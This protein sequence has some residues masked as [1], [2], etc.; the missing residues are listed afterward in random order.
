MRGSRLGLV[1]VRSA[2]AL[3][4]LAA[5]VVA[6]TD[7]SGWWWTAWSA[8]LAV[9]IARPVGIVNLGRPVRVVLDTPVVASAIVLLS[10]A[11]A[12]AA[13][14]V[15]MAIGLAAHTAAGA[16]PH[17]ALGAV[18]GFGRHAI[19]ATAAA[20]LV[21]GWART[22][23]ASMLVAT[24]AA[25][26]C[27]LAVAYVSVLAEMALVGGRLDVLVLRQLAAP[28]L[29][30]PPAV[31]LA[32]AAVRLE[33]AGPG[34]SLLLALPVAAVA[35]ATSVAS[36]SRVE[37]AHAGALFLVAEAGAVVDDESVVAD[38]LRYAI[39]DVLAHA[40]PSGVARGVDGSLTVTL[41][42]PDALDDA[43]RV[44]LATAEAIASSAVAR[45]RL[46]HQV[47]R[48]ATH[49]PLTGLATRRLLE[50]RL[51]HHHALAERG[52]GEY[53]VCYIDLDNLKQVNDAFGHAA[54]DAVLVTVAARLHT[55]VRATD[56]VARVGG[57]EFVVLLALGDDRSP[58][59]SAE[60]IRAAVARPV[61]FDGRTLQ[62]S[63]SIGVA[64]P[65]HGE[66]PEAV[67]SRADL[68]AIEVKRSGKDGVAIA[69]GG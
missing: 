60:R 3:V 44:L 17:G 62:V 33:Q 5:F 50:A 66:Q 14:S 11:D 65:S 7:L 61:D 26:V 31:A 8:A 40:R 12:V 28:L 36:R 41:E 58:A 27:Y 69:S 54:G 47:E 57:D 38:T 68:A 55:A 34:S 67:V 4:G 1:A 25:A 52:V 48:E 63:A 37:R 51:A 23:T 46:F 43:E 42:M 20:W 10:P 22:P 59:S 2:F 21:E 16:R 9:A 24:I 64:L 49:D 30:V 6:A 29:L 19:A 39:G 13:V 32:A 18:A 35:V 15:G 56:L 53:A 45:I